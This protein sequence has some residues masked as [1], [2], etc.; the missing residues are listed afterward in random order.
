M[1]KSKK[2]FTKKWIIS[3]IELRNGAD[4]KY[5]VTRR[6]PDLSVSETKIFKQQ[7]STNLLIGG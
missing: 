1:K 7:N 3:I 6:I 2:H 5:K 4:R